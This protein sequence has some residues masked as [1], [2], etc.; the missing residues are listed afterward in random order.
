[1]TEPTPHEQALM[2]ARL[3]VLEHVVGL[4][5]REGLLKAG[6]G[7][8]DI[9]AFGASVKEVLTNRTPA[10]ASNK[11]IGEAADLF[12]SAIASEVGSQESQ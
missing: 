8:K 4:M 1:M 2:Q 12:F 9:L 10:G 7:P 6:K 11:E 5:L 3:T